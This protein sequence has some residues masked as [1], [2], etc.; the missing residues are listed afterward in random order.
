MNAEEYL[1]AIVRQHR[2]PMMMASVCIVAGDPTADQASRASGTASSC[3]DRGR[4]AVRARPRRVLAEH[5][6]V[7]ARGRVRA[8]LLP[9]LR[10]DG[11]RRRLD[12]AVAVRDLLLARE[13]R[14]PGDLDLELRVHVR[15]PG[16]G[17]RSRAAHEARALGGRGDRQIAGVAVAVT[18]TVRLRRVRR[19]RTVVAGVPAAV[20]VG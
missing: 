14:I 20:R 4:R 10:R 2:A 8:G 11:P 5:A 18:V 9:L 19:G 3:A 15:K 13:V 16:D 12:E 6:D 17:R 7:E 1:Y